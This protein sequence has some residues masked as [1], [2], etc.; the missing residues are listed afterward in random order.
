MPGFDRAGRAVER[1][2]ERTK[3]AA[4]RDLDATNIKN[5]LPSRVVPPASSTTRGGVMLSDDDPLADDPTAD[6]GV[7]PAA[8]RADHV[9]PSSGGSLSMTDGSTTVDPLTALTVAGATLADDGGG[10]GTLTITGGSAL[11]I[12]DGITTVDPVTDLTLSGATIADDGGGAAT[13]TVTG[14]GGGGSL[15]LIAEQ[16][17]L[18]NAAT[19]TFSSIPNTYRHLRLVA[20]GRM[21][22]ATTEDYVYIRFNG[23]TG[24]NYDEIRSN[25]GGF[26]QSSAQTK[27]RIG[28]FPG[29]TAPSGSAGQFELLIPAYALT[30]FHKT[31]RSNSGVWD[32]SSSGV[33]NEFFAR[34]R[35]T[36]AINALELSLG[37]G[38]FITGSI[39]SLYGME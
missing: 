26:G 34:W 21:T 18:S 4:Q 16:L 31:V 14:G 32:Q 38:S 28:D 2:N 8:S 24:S 35:D 17:L 22:T 5:Q 36:S 39:F 1:M 3:D 23:D 33:M 20:V 6:S 13:L 7:S 12:T 10:A 29:S 11:S 27:S 37:S 9:H 15:T 25:N 19:V 30:T